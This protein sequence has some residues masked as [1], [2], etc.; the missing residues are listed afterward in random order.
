[1]KSH[2]DKAHRRRVLAETRPGFL[3]L[4]QLP[5]PLDLGTSLLE[6]AIHHL[7]HVIPFIIPAARVT[8]P[9]SGQTDLRITLETDRVDMDTKHHLFGSSVVDVCTDIFS[10]SGRDV[11]EWVQ[12]TDAG[13]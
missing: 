4:L 6:A 1:M 12:D 3:S 9:G 5:L 11:V 13:A 2:Q 7:P 8:P 10:D